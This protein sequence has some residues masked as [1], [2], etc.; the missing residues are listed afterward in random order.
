M[1]GAMHPRSRRCSFRLLLAVTFL[2]GWLA[3]DNHSLL[4]AP[5]AQ[6]S[7]QEYI[8][9]PG[10]SLSQISATFYGTANRW[11]EI[12]E[13]TNA[14]AREDSSFATLANPRLIYPGQK[15]WI[16]SSS[17]TEQPATPQQPPAAAP[18]TSEPT[19]IITTDAPSNTL[20]AMVGQLSARRTEPDTTCD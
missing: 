20:T 14:K 2:V 5:H 17:S 11:P 8:V 10:D 16:P 6:E 18:T 12:F 7:G 3:L 9:Q 19:T 4:A 15:L 13:A 1:Y